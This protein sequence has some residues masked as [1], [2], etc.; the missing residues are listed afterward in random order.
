MSYCPDSIHPVDRQRADPRPVVTRLWSTHSWMTS[1]S[2]RWPW[3]ELSPT[4]RTMSRDWPDQDS[5][6]REVSATSV[7]QE[8]VVCRRHNIRCRC[9]STVLLSEN[10]CLCTSVSMQI[11]SYCK[12][13]KCLSLSLLALSSLSLSSL[14]PSLSFPFYPPSLFDRG[15]QEGRKAC[16]KS[17]REGR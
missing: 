17:V 13:H 1:S 7:Q 3:H 14:S 11:I 12:R 10:N 4:G 2:R 9:L 6:P 5:Y 8:H 15:R 16:R